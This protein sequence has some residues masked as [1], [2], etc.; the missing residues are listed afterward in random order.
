MNK[1]NN[2]LP[3]TKLLTN[4]QSLGSQKPV[5]LLTQ[6]SMNPVHKQHINI[7]ELAKKEIEAQAINL[8]VVGGFISTAPNTYIKEKLGE[9]LFVTLE[10]RIKML[11]LAV[12]DSDWIEVDEWGSKPK[13]SKDITIKT[14]EHLSTYLNKNPEILKY[15]QNVKVFYVCG[16][17]L[18]KRH[19]IKGYKELVDK[20]FG[21]IIVGRENNPNWKQEASSTLNTIFG[22]S[23]WKNSIYLVDGKDSEKTSSTKVR[24][25]LKNQ[26]EKGLSELLHPK[27]LE[28]IK[29]N[30]L[31]GFKK[32]KKT[33]PTLQ[34]PNLWKPYLILASGMGIALLGLGIYWVL[35]R[36][37]KNLG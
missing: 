18:V 26:E 29:S 4:C 27:V 10:K 33:E 31:Y 15:S 21:V 20:G 24:D 11:K 30:E 6:G 36:K 3:I 17:D 14:L 1:I 34:Q 35:N 8:K 2:S 5:I 19:G 16:E 23:S 13:A 32:R 22:S 25:K 7:L 9:E 28:Y 12:K 37:K